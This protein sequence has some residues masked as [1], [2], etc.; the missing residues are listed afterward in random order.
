MKADPKGSAFFLPID[1]WYFYRLVKAREA[2]SDMRYLTHI[3]AFFVL[4]LTW[5]TANAAKPVENLEALYAQLLDD[6]TQ[7]GRKDGLAVRLMDYPALAGDERWSRLVGSL[8]EVSAEQLQSPD[9]RKAF[10][11]NA[12]NILAIDMVVEHWPLRSLKSVGSLVNP[13]WKHDAGVVAGQPVTLSYLEHDVLRAM[14][15]PRVHMAINCASLSCPDLRH[16]PYSASRIDQQLDDQVERFLAQD[17][18]GMRLDRAD[19][20]ARLSAIFD[21]FEEDFDTAGGV[22]GFVRRY[23][24]D[25]PA[26]WAVDADLPYNWGVNGKLSAHTLRAMRDE[27]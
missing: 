12:Y 10:Y 18:K 5:Q 24:P 20:T 15:D 25:L 3:A 4:V 23:R 21:W 22:E 8:S 14:G 16:E 1:S 17:Y 19:R 26:S 7:E 2:E 6:H 13:V 27:F 9:A 11:L